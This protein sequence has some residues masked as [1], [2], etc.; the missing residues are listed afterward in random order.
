MTHRRTSMRETGRSRFSPRCVA[1]G[2]GIAPRG[3]MSV[4]LTGGDTL[5]Q[6]ACATVQKERDVCVGSTGLDCTADFAYRLKKRSSHH[7]SRRNMS[8]LGTRDSSHGVRGAYHRA[9]RNAAGA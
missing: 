6:G 2:L 4:L 3:L 8:P 5:Q 1:R 7:S 9:V